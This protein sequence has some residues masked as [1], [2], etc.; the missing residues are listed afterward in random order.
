MDK[1]TL[2]KIIRQKAEQRFSKE[3]K[4]LT[5]FLYNHP[6]AKVLK[7]GES[8]L[9]A[10]RQNSIFTEFSLKDKEFFS[11]YAEEKER[12]IKKYEQLEYD[13]LLNKL[14]DIKYIF[15]YSNE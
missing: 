15:N 14:D 4:E 5:G 12:L 3:E 9:I 6:L 2:E 13:Q 7:V 8:Y 10:S 1:T 11:N